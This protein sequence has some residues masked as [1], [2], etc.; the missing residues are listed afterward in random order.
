MP[1]SQHQEEANEIN[2]AQQLIRVGKPS[3]ARQ[4]LKAAVRAQPDSRPLRLLLAELYREIDCPDQAGRW[5]I[6]VD[7][8]TTPREQDRL[9][10]LLASSGVARQDVPVF[11]ALPSRN[12]GEYATIGAL[13]DGP[14]A[15]YRPRYDDKIVKRPNPRSRFFTAVAKVVWV[16]AF[17][18]IG[19][20]LITSAIEW[21][22]GRDELLVLAQWLGD[23]GAVLLGFAV[24]M[25]AAAAAA[26]RELRWA[27]T[28]G[29]VALLI[30]GS[31][32]ARV[33]DLFPG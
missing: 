27:A 11:L 28:L 30:T 1:V 26:Q 16:V 31:A 18:A 9:A 7:G 25:H 32:I 20:H 2:R 3:A 5:G 17:V 29:V 15:R 14:V 4:A 12:L 24:L 23:S 8:W 13:L 22:P 33:A 21:F 19:I 6:L 10:R